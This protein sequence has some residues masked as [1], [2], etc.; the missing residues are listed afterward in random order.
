MGSSFRHL[1]APTV[2][3]GRPAQVRET[4]P[5]HLFLPGSAHQT[6]V[7]GLGVQKHIPGAETD[8]ECGL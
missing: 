3:S 7:P 8:R 1:H 2:W 4:L 6:G 5:Q